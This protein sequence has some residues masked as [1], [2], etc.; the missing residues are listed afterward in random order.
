MTI[1]NTTFNNGDDKI[2]AIGFIDDIANEEEKKLFF[3]EL[4]D[5]SMEMTSYEKYI[6]QENAEETEGVQKPIPEAV[7]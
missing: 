2:K 7:L 5:T 1:I 4:Y 3:S 6:N